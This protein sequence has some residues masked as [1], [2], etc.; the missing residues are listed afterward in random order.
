[1]TTQ[2]GAHGLERLTYGQKLIAEAGR[3]ALQ[4]AEGG[5]Q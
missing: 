3:R 4:Q 5:A 2:A 1:M